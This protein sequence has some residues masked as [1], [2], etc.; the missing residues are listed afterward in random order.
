M[1]KFTDV[2]YGLTASIFKNKVQVQQEAG[3]QF[4]GCVSQLSYFA[5]I[6]ARKM[7]G[8][9]F[10]KIC[11]DICRTTWKYITDD[12]NLHSQGR[13]NFKSNVDSEPLGI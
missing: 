9:C 6:L 4:A 7:E 3:V 11:R 12:S 1:Y 10:C 5:H 2:S 13:G 8:E